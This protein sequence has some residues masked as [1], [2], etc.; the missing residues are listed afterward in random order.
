[1]QDVYLQHHGVK[2]QKWGVRRYQ[3]PDGTL[4]A[5]G[6]KR[7]AKQYTKQ[8]NDLDKKSVKH[9]GN[10]MKADQQFKRKAREG[11][12]LM[13]KSGDEGF[14]K[15]SDK[16]QKIESKM[17]EAGKRRDAEMKAFKETDSKAWKVLAEAAE[18]GYTV[19]SKQ[20]YRDSEAGRT[21]ISN[22]LIGP[23]STA[24]I[25]AVRN[26]LY[27]GEYPTIDKRT[28]RTVH[29]SPNLIQGN[30]YKVH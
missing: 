29:Q 20:V 4:T 5:A 27:S 9:I 26:M 10:Y 18:K 12:R 23:V 8:L 15:N 25:S 22:I 6:R 7:Q 1:M 2:G 3:N 11:V 13:K 24:T 17:I 30:K 16:F 21:F 28:G 14:D 19:N